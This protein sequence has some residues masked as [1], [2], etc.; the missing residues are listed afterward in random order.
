MKKI[1]LIAISILGGLIFTLGWPVNGFPMFLFIAFI[2]FLFV[3]DYL[4]KNKHD[5]HWAS[6]FFLTY[7]GFLL[8]NALDTY[9][10]IN[11]TTV[12]GIAAS[13]LNAFFMSIPF[14]LYHISK[15]I[16]Y[17]S[18][19]GY[20]L[21]IFYWISWEF[22]H[23]D[24]DL[25]WPW[26][27]LGN[28]FSGYYKWVQWYE[29]TGSFGG[30]FWIIL[31]NILIYKL[32]NKIYKQRK[33]FR[34]QYYQIA[35]ILALIIFPIILSFSIYYNYDEKS[36]PLDIVVIQPNLDPYSEQYGLSPNVI[37]KRIF[38]LVDQKADSTV[39]FIVC[40][41]S[42]NQQ[43]I[44]EHRIHRYSTI[45]NIYKYLQNDYPNT[46]F[47]IGAS[48]YDF[49][50]DEDTLNNAARKI[51]NMPGT[52]YFAYN[53]AIYLNSEKDI[54]LYHKSKL[55]PGVEKMPSWR[56]LR[57]LE[58]FAI[59]L[60]GTIGTLATDDV[61]KS[62]ITPDS[63]KIATLIC[64]ES[65]YG[66]FVS[67]FVKNGAKAVFVITNDGW[68][69]DTPGYKQHFEFSSLRAIETRRS[70]ARSANTGISG[71][72]NQKGDILQ[73]TE[74]WVEDV[75]REKINLN[76]ELTFY[77]KNGDYIARIS[78]LITALFI[79]VTISMG[80]TNK[81]KKLGNS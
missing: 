81:K 42:A 76:D 77:V 48:T 57:P 27:N 25:S 4:S 22:F 31:V 32:L 68:W 65:A 71:F 80:I 6:V 16:L 29:Y 34:S 37:M 44:F 26:L 63:L 78:A 3:E 17:G 45:R 56:I 7:P 61:R 11:S 64:Y 52:Y 24:W 30:A 10:I 35:G 20:F 54:Q 69:G 67:K 21:L 33:L 72:F 19:K 74:Y 2:P 36:D 12:G 50:N 75:I 8:W 49:I 53:T 73:S 66:E 59:D 23:L 5:F 79:L 14:T 58:K 1:H 43:D 41:E 40:P 38:E 70:I 18:G 39:D 15:R 9:W 60:G 62:F 47:I 51:P 55:T 28:G 46:G 13:F